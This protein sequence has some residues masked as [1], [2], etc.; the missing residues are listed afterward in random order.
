MPAGQ[1]LNTNVTYRRW[2][3]VE[4][5]RLA[6]AL[7]V[8]PAIPI[9]G[10]FLVIGLLTHANFPD[11]QVLIGLGWL[12]GIVCPWSL[13]AGFGYLLTVVRWR[14][15]V[16]RAE[17][18]LLGAGAAFAWPTAMVIT[19]TV[20]DLAMGSGSSREPLAIQA[21]KFL[22]LLG[23][24]IEIGLILALFG[25]PGGWAFWRIGVYPAKSPAADLVKVFD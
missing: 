5:W 14:G 18:L 21:H 20:I 13:I 7:A 3:D 1:S 22:E 23:D 8:A 19:G 17:C 11:L 12:L 10:T 2:H 6:V 9:L 16:G 25:L 4:L 15:I 24:A